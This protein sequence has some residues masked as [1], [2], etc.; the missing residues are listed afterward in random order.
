MNTPYTTDALF[1][2]F[3]WLFDDEQPFDYLRRDS[4]GYRNVKAT[5][6]YPDNGRGAYGMAAYE[7]FREKYGSLAAAYND[8]YAFALRT[9]RAIHPTKWRELK[10]DLEYI[11]RDGTIND[12]R[13]AEIELEWRDTAWKEWIE[14]DVVH[15]FGIRFPDLYAFQNWLEMAKDQGKYRALGEGTFENNAFSLGVQAMREDMPDEWENPEAYILCNTWSAEKRIVLMI[16]DEQVYAVRWTEWPHADD[17]S[18]VFNA[19]RNRVQN[20]MAEYN[21]E[22]DAYHVAMLVVI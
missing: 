14:D 3:P 10:A 5:Q 2:E 8:A 7:Y 1:E 9:G 4:P 6:H 20:V 21:R 13:A 22:H 15:H 12:D 19:F 17:A 16:D 11:N 18:E